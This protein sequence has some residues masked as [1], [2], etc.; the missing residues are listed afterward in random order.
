MAGERADANNV[1]KSL[2]LQVQVADLLRDQLN[3]LTIDR[4]DGDGLLY[5][6]A[7]LRVNLPADQVKALDRGISV[8]RSYHLAT[9]PERK[10]IKEAK[11]GDNI[12]VTLT[13]VAK[14]NLHYAMITDPIP[15]GTEAVNPRL[16]TTAIGQPPRLSRDDPFGRGYGWW[17]FSQT[18]LRD[19]KVVLYATYLPKGTYRYVYT[20]RAGLAGEYRVMP[21]TAEEFYAPEVF[22]RSDGALFI[23]KPSEDSTN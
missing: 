10:P 3:R 9:D 20:L 8:S 18:E 7:R 2:T 11:V 13:I 19:E 16:A 23:L 14:R 22:G 4:T 5:Y 15:A 6:M 1:R 12:V 17:W 21:A